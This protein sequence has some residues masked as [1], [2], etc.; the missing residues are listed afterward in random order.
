[1]TSA[2]A[3]RIAAASFSHAGGRDY[4]EDALGDCEAAG[5]LRLFVLA[6]G[7]GGHGGG[8]VASRIAV[9][10]AQ[11][12][13]LQL[14][15][16]SPD[17]LRHCIRQADRAVAA[18]QASAARVAH[19][20]STVAVLLINYERGHALFGNLGDS[21]G[22]VFRGS[23]AK[24]H[25]RDHSLVQRFV[26]AGLYPAERLRQHPRRNVLYASLGAN[27]D[28]ADPY[29]SA[30]PIDLQPGDGLMLCSDGVWELLEDARL[31]ELHATSAD[32]GAWSE[33]LAGAIRASMPPDHD[34]YSAC[35]LRCLPG[36]SS[37][38]DT[39]PPGLRAAW[40]PDPEV[41][42]FPA[43]PAASPAAPR[44]PAKD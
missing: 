4:N 3:I 5:A 42:A 34:N 43:T 21:R 36:L 35:L 14:P 13:F 18:Q 1:M 12:A 24:V 25:T 38:D 22:Y 6:D 17:T 19:M 31:G 33:A 39:I 40:Q 41:T 30:E 23:Q 10:A 27:E 2:G 15:V 7:V 16:F 9:Q 32:A 44:T 20:A 29:V 37:D 28:L 11:E 26:D 8:D